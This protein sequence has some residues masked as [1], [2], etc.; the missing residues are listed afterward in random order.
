[1]IFNIVLLICY[2]CGLKNIKDYIIKEMANHGYIGQS[3]V[4][5]AF[6]HNYV[7]Q[8]D[9][10]IERLKQM[11]NNFIKKGEPPKIKKNKKRQ[12]F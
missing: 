12:H 1:M 2:F 7:K 8:L 4:S 11:K 3:D 9:R 6:C 10:L 5:H